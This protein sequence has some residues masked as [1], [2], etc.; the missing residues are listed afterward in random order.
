MDFKKLCE[1]RRTERAFDSKVNISDAEL[2]SIFKLAF[3]TPSA[4]NLQHW[5]FVVTRQQ[6][7]KSDLFELCYFQRQILDCSA[8]I[9]I[10]GN[11]RAYLDAELI[12]KDQ[13]T[14]VKDKFIPMI[15]AIYSDDPKLQRDEVMRSGGLVA[16]SLIYAAKNEGWDTGP[17]I[18]FDAEKVS[19]R[20]NLEENITP[21]MMITVGKRMGRI[22]LEA[23]PFRYSLKDV[24]HLETYSNVVLDQA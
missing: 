10:C 14:E 19:L 2:R 22:S 4:F 8:V 15:K 3:N 6:S 9:T 16:M 7:V 13:T 1:E 17:M 5:R 18:G 21:V 11:L 20:L 12:Y 23:R 24:V